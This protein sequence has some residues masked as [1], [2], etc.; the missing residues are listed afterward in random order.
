MIIGLPRPCG[1]AREDR[2]LRHRLPEPAEAEDDEV[3]AVGRH[4]LGNGMRRMLREHVARHH[5]R[6]AEDMD[7][8]GAVST[9]ETRSA[10][11][12]SPVRHQMAGS[13]RRA[14]AGDRG[15]DGGVDLLVSQHHDDRARVLDVGRGDQ[16]GCR[17][18]P[19]DADEAL[20]LDRIG[21]DQNDVR[22][23]TEGDGQGFGGTHRRR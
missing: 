10:I 22:V 18:G 7:A 8:R 16:L 20:A 2:F 14:A 23:G 6:L 19:L 11:S 13:A 5:L 17:R 15:R 21:R 3:H 1:D 4:A 9:A 12:R